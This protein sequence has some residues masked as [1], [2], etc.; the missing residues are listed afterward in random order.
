[1]F[2]ESLWWSTEPAAQRARLGTL[3][4]ARQ[5]AQITDLDPKLDDELRPTE[6]KAAYFGAKA[7]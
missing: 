5:T 6:P 7:P 2:E 1:M 3:P 4:G